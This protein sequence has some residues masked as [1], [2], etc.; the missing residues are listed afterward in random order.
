[1]NARTINQPTE[2]GSIPF[3]WNSSDFI[4]QSGSNCAGIIYLYSFRRHSGQLM[5]LEV[6]IGES[7]TTDGA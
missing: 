4:P 7:G 6:A 3:I 5:L 2:K 1:M